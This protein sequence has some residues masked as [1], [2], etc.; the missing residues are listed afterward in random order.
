MEWHKPILDVYKKLIRARRSLPA[1]RTGKFK[2]LKTFNAVYAY[3]RYTSD[4]EVIIILNPREELPQ[5]SIPRGSQTTDAIWR[6]ILSEQSVYQEDGVF[7]F[8]PL[9]AE[10]AFILVKDLKQQENKYII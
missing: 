7:N 5:L 8:A 6:D 1:L 3:K 9:P 2:K 4:E 10:Q